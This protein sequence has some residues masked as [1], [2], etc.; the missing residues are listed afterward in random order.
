MHSS[1]FYSHVQADRLGL[2]RPV[3]PLKLVF[4]DRMSRLIQEDGLPR[5]N[6]YAGWESLLHCHRL[7]YS[8]RALNCRADTF[9]RYVWHDFSPFPVRIP[10]VLTIRA[11][12]T[13]FPSR[14][15]PF[16]LHTT[17]PSYC[18]FAKYMQSDFCLYARTNLLPTKSSARSVKSGCTCENGIFTL[19][20]SILKKFRRKS[21]VYITWK[22]I[23]MILQ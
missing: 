2:K 5:S 19:H 15:L 1:V 3:D 11:R 12:R 13:A 17:S 20:L 8:S 21:Q 9:L 4:R 10:H 16:P 7:V 23:L 14:I 18:H 22:L 6:L